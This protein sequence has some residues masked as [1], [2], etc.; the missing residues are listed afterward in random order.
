MP[1]LWRGDQTVLA[2]VKTVTRTTSRTGRSATVFKALVLS[3][4]SHYKCSHTD[5]N[6]VDVSRRRP[7]LAYQISSESVNPRQSYDVI[8][9]SQDGGHG[10]ANLL[11]VAELVTELV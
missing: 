3:H 9:I 11:P 5:Y 4:A 2:C 7:E 8:F 10:F 6:E 1:V